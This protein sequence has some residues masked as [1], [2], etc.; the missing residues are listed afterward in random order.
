MLAR[1]YLQG[2]AEFSTNLEKALYYQSIPVAS[3]NTLGTPHSGISEYD[4]A[5]HTIRACNQLSCFQAGL[6]SDEGTFQVL[7]NLFDGNLARNEIINVLASSG[8]SFKSIFSDNIGGTKKIPVQV[9]IG[10]AK[11]TLENPITG[12]GS[13]TESEQETRFSSGDK[14]NI[15]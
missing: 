13:T 8:N 12:G 5:L 14:P 15:H 2:L 9:L 11:S 1:T 4:D 6:T 10:I 7:K 3:L